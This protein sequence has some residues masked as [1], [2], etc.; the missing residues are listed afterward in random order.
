MLGAAQGGQDVV[1]VERAHAV[2]AVLTYLQ[3]DLTA[4]WRGHG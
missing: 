4:G 2:L 3:K 1:R